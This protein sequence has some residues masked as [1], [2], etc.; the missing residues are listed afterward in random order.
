MNVFFEIMSGFILNLAVALIIIRYVYYPTNRDHNYIFTYITFNVLIYFV[1]GLLRDVQLSVGFGFGLLAV[2]STL[3]FRT[4]AVPIKHMTYLF[5]F[6]TI[7]FMNTLFMATRIT[8]PELILVNLVVIGILYGAERRWGFQSE[9]SKQIRYERIELIKPEHYQ[10][11]LNDLRERTGLDIKRCVIDE[12]NFMTDTALLTVYY[13]E[14]YEAV[15]SHNVAQREDTL[16]TIE[17]TQLD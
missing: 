17:V 16:E 8:Y 14:P 6:V 12:V 1:S 2:F 11:L 7:P 15:I 9:G 3:R 10:L 4:R 5:I 13:D